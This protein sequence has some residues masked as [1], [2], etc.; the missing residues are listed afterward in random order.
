MDKNAVTQFT[1]RATQPLRP[2]SYAYCAR[3]LRKWADKIE[4]RGNPQTPEER[5]ALTKAV[6]GAARFMRSFFA[7]HNKLTIDR[8]LTTGRETRMTTREEIM[9]MTATKH[10]PD[11]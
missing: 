3:Q 7:R 8:K 2:D 5:A 6:N 9:I 11:K 4:T 1:K 10:N